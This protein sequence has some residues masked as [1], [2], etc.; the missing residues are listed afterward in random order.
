M[1]PK[2]I[3]SLAVR[4]LGLFFLYHGLAA[5]PSLLSIFPAGSFWNF[6]TNIVALGWPFVVAYWLI[7][8]ASPVVRLAYPNS[9]N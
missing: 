1:T 8:G 9:E 2:S 7:Q 3:F 5:L 6:V 4:I